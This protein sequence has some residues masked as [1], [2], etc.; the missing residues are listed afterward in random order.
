MIR[1]LDGLL[2]ALLCALLLVGTA[3]ADAIVEHLRA[4]EQARFEGTQEAGG[5]VRLSLADDGGSV[6]RFEVEGVAGGGCSWDTLTLEN[7][8]GEVALVDGRFMATNADGDTLTGVLHTDNTPARRFEGTIQ[9]RDPV[10]GCE[11]PA[12][13]WAASESVWNTGSEADSLPQHLEQ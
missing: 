5:P 2:T 8:G 12:L 9:V 10:K 13:Y 7:W 4:S 11:T 3:K 6:S 1:M